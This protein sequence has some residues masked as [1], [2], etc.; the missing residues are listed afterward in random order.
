MTE[1]ATPKPAKK[2]LT[3]EDID[4]KAKALTEK[5]GKLRLKENKRREL[6]ENIGL[7]TTVREF[8]AA[9]FQDF[10]SFKLKVTGILA[11]EF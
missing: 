8:A 7:I 9:G 3:A 1:Q 11:I 5:A 4:K 6:T 2:T 10:D